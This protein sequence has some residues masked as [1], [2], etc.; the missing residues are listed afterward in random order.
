MLLLPITVAK[1]A[2]V[3]IEAREGR[4]FIGR[5]SKASPNYTVTSACCI[6][7][8]PVMMLLKL[9]GSSLQV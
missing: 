6:A 4:F 8:K 7:G 9:H 2:S 5:I 3:L 1:I